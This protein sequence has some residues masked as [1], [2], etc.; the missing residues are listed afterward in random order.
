MAYSL[1][2][3]L[4]LDDYQELLQLPIAAFNGLSKPDETPVYECNTLWNQGMREMLQTY[5]RQAQEKREEE[6][7]YFLT[8]HY[9]NYERHESANPVIL[10]HKHFIIAGQLASSVVEEDVALD[11]GVESA[12]NDPVEFTVTTTVTDVDELYVYHANQDGDS[13]RITPSSVTISGG[14]ATIKIPRSR[15]VNPA[16]KDNRADALSY[17]ENDNFVTTVDVVRLYNDPSLAGRYVSTPLQRAIYGSISY[18][19]GV[20]TYQTAVVYAD[21]ERASRLSIVTLYPATYAD[22]VWTGRAFTDC[23]VP[24]YVDVSYKSGIRYSTNSK[25]L[26]IRLAHTLMPNPVCSCP[27]LEQYWKEDREATAMWTP[28]GNRMGAMAAWVADSRAKVGVAGA[29][30]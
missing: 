15:L 24:A 4:T 22:G 7:G 29:F 28:Y 13:Y 26:T 19:G 9:V 18:P 14:V 1:P 25:L 2:D 27:Y 8:P 30:S 17:Y 3:V 12:P 11:L 23:Y 21:G 6:L 20:E 10:Q 5:L 16:L